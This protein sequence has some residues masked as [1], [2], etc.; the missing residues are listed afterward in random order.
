MPVALVDIKSNVF[1][2]LGVRHG[3]AF[4]CD[5]ATERRNNILYLSMLEPLDCA[6]DSNIISALERLL[7]LMTYGA[8]KRS[9]S[10]N[11]SK[12]KPLEC[13][14]NSNVASALESLL[15]QWWSGRRG[16]EQLSLWPTS[17]RFTSEG[18]WLAPSAN[19]GWPPSGRSQSWWHKI[20]SAEDSKYPLHHPG[21][22]LR[23]DVYP[24]LALLW[25]GFLNDLPRYPAC[26][27]NA[28]ECYSVNI[29]T[30]RRQTTMG[31]SFYWI[32]LFLIVTVER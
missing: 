10:V 20:L 16:S 5:P 12:L 22:L 23:D 27:N 29:A 3:E 9:N 30:S 14:G 15:P 18:D 1:A 24:L 6:G 13:V 11:R 32:S 21:A 28:R 25:L 8:R 19:L 7:S 17:I 31:T 2:P 26:G 4:T